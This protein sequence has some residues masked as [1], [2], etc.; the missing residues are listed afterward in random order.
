[1]TVYV[2]VGDQEYIYNSLTLG[3]IIRTLFENQKSDDVYPLSTER[4]EEILE[5][6]DPNKEFK[7]KRIENQDGHS[8]QM[9]MVIDLYE[10]ADV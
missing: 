5:Q 4:A 9:G 10:N 3:R 6:I 8:R 2:N 7:L 1:M